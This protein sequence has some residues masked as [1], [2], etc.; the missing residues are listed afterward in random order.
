V[1]QSDSSDEEEVVYV[2]KEK[3]KAKPK[4]VRRVYQQEEQRVPENPFGDVYDRMF[5]LS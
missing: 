3:V 5:K 1:E 4:P 2:K